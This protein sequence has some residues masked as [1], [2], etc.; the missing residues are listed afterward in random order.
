MNTAEDRFWDK[1]DVLGDDDCWEWQATKIHNGYGHFRLDGELELAHRASY[2][3]THGEIPNIDGTDFRG[4]CVLHTCDNRACCNPE[5]LFIGTHTDNM[6]DMMEKGR[7]NKP[8][9]ERH[10]CAKLTEKDV[11]AIRDLYDYGWYQYEIAS[12]FGVGQ[13]AISDIITKKKW[14]HV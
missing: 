4:T 8:Q 9:G 13:T 6:K 7:G 11:A 14:S 12:L 5:H 10:G 1:V 2:I 3:F